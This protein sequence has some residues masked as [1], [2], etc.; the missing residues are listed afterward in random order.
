R[1][2]AEEAVADQVAGAHRDRELLAGLHGLRRL[3]DQQ[4]RALLLGRDLAERGVDAAR[5][6][7][8]PVV[9]LQVAV[10]AVPAEDVEPVVVLVAAV[11][12][13]AVVVVSVAVVVLAL[14]LVVLAVVAVAAALAVGVGVLLVGVLLVALGGVLVT[15]GG[16]GLG[17]VVAVVVRGVDSRGLR[18]VGPA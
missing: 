6:L 17:V 16:V 11:V 14:V 3:G 4:R 1:G 5:R 2:S 9:R 10:R 18:G 15:V 8:E 13:V 12:V 7:L